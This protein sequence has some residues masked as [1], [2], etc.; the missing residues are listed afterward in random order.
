MFDRPDVMGMAS[1]MAQNASARLGLIAKNIANADTPG[2]RAQTA[3]RFSD[4]YRQAL[5]LPMR[6][7]RPGHLGASLSAGSAR[8]SVASGHMAPNGNGVSLENEMVAAAGARRDHD[9][10]LAIYKNALG[11]LRSS[12]GRR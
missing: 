2:Y 3:A 10:A 6:S 12:L 4:T 8:P 7:T 9:M 1:A 11:L 5:D